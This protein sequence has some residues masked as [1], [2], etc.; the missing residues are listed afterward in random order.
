L[1]LCAKNYKEIEMFYNEAQDILVNEARSFGTEQVQLA[2]AF[3][4]VLCEKIVA[5]RDYPPFNRAAM[6]GYALRYEDVEKGLRSFVIKETIFAGHASTVAIGPGECYKIMTGAATP[7]HANFIIRREDTKEEGQQVSILTSTFKPLQN[8]AQRGEDLKQ[9][10][11]IIDR[12]VIASP[13]VISL[14]AAIGKQTVRVEKL[15]SVAIVTTGNEVKRMDEQVSEVEIRN[16]NAWLL[17]SLLH[18]QGVQHLSMLHMA[19]DPVQLQHAFS[20][21]LQFDMVISCGGVSA[22]DADFVPDAMAALGVQKLFHKLMIRPGKPIW[23]GKTATGK[24]VFALPGNPFSCM[25]T[26]TLFVLGYLN[27]C[28]GLPAPP[29]LSMTIKD[30]R[31]KKTYLDEF[32]PVKIIPGTNSVEILP[33]NGSGDIRAALFADGIARHPREKTILSPGEQI[34][35]LAL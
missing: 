17:Q 32:F 1:R 33:F 12:P 4:R 2:H 6:D 22:G 34:E 23:C 25:V 35:Y 9:G 29:V 11:V 21:A 8:I 15:P 13:S 14:L 31:V 20:H 19:D 30:E 28:Y 3:G 18:K 27:A 10:E 26:F 7:H 16:S 24:M 5:D